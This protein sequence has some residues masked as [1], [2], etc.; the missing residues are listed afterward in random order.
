MGTCS[1]KKSFVSHTGD[2]T[3]EFKPSKAGQSDVRRPIHTNKVEPSRASE[4][5]HKSQSGKED[6]K[7]PDI[8]TNQSDIRTDLQHTDDEAEA[9]QMVRELNKRNSVL[10]R[11]AT[12]KKEVKAK[13]KTC[14][15]TTYVASSDDM[16]TL[17]DTEFIEQ[18]IDE[19]YEHVINSHLLQ[20][21]DSELLEVIKED[22]EIE[23]E[24]DTI[25]LVESEIIDE[26]NLKH[27]NQ[28]NENQNSGKP[29]A[30][31]LKSA[32]GKS[33]KSLNRSESKDSVKSEKKKKQEKNKDNHKERLWT[34]RGTAIKWKQEKVYTT[35][36]KDGTLFK[37]RILRKPSKEDAE[38]AAHKGRIIIILV[39]VNNV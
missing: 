28:V 25:S 30:D 17:P 26:N 35:V 7:H 24:N 14:H 10:D 18:T 32:S 8:L 20:D 5:E 12:Q 33:G 38:K 15:S 29:K 13:L 22:E 9:I 4:P 27:E 1:G 31:K 36:G 19:V 34:S 23:F 11:K 37:I 2:V 39:N 21:K 3:V 16:R 6:Y